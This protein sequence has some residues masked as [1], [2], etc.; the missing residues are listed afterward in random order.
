MKIIVGIQK[1]ET[2]KRKKLKDKRNDSDG[3]GNSDDMDDGGY[4]DNDVGGDDDG[5]ASE[6]YI[7]EAGIEY[8]DTNDGDEVK[9]DNKDTHHRQPPPPPQKFRMDRHRSSII[10][11]KE[12]CANPW[13]AIRIL[14]KIT[15]GVDLERKT[16]LHINS[17][18]ERY[19]RN[20]VNAIDKVAFKVS[21]KTL[22]IN[23]ETEEPN[24]KQSHSSN[25]RDHQKNSK[26]DDR[27]IRIHH[28]PNMELVAVASKILKS[29]LNT[30]WKN[31][32]SRDKY[33][34][35]CNNIAYVPM[36]SPKGFASIYIAR[37]H[38]NEN[39]KCKIMAV[40]SCYSGLADLIRAF[41][42]LEKQLGT[43]KKIA[44]LAGAVNEADRTKIMNW[45]K[46]SD[47]VRYLVATVNYME[48]GHNFQQFNVLII[49]NP[50]YDPI[51]DM[52][53]SGR[54]SR[55]GQQ[56]NPHVYRLILKDTTDM[57][58]KAC[59][60]EKIAQ[61][62]SLFNDIYLKVKSSIEEEERLKREKKMQKKKNSKKRKSEN[63]RGD[64]DACEVSPKMDINSSG[65]GGSKGHIST[66]SSQISTKKLVKEKK[67]D[68]IELNRHIISVGYV[69]QEDLEKITALARA[70]TENYFEKCMK[71]NIDPK[72]I[73]GR[74]VDSMW[75][76]DTSMISIEDVVDTASMHKSIVKD[77]VKG[78]DAKD[79]IDNTD[80][81]ENEQ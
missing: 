63:I 7:E 55:P 48:K 44:V 60:D 49:G 6:S 40:S 59:Q 34:D 64:D 54:L 38:I 20:Q 32:E 37:K 30:N 53:L 25:D 21:G 9:I 29:I 33:E 51:V 42:E 3:D 18:V 58:A 15:N 12:I 43:N 31:Q 61:I 81:D 46:Y 71:P 10:V 17:I 36:I 66:A 69:S 76:F 22:Y 19:I 68:V 79:I 16:K 14:P 77:V 75:V 8:M 27:Y 5:D 67:N 72:N 41:E 80:E 62:H 47:E 56:S 1:K 45:A 39:P 13:S 28:E 57:H 35:L 4:S 2:K 73:A 50:D 52:Q 24:K 65:G 74:Y 78:Q 23:D 11:M 26:H 70:K